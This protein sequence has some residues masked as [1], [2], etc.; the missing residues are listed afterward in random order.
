MLW[1]IESTITKSQNTSHSSPGCG[2]T[3]VPAF[4]SGKITS[5][6]Q[7]IVQKKGKN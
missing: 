1:S 3:G 7:I 6:N 2:V 5:K 4:S